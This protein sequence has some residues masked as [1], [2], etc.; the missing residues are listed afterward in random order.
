MGEKEAF[1]TSSH[2]IG[3]ENKEM[4]HCECRKK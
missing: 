3:I 1:K 2:S 4:D